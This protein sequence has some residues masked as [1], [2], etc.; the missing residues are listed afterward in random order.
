M[1]NRFDNVNAI[2]RLLIRQSDASQ[3]TS[4]TYS[5]IESSWVGGRRAM[6]S[7]KLPAKCSRQIIAEMASK[8]ERNTLWKMNIPLRI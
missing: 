4:K 8:K 1:Y 2:L 7:S 3:A 5:R 6:D